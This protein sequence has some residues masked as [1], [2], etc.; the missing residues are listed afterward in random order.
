MASLSTL[1]HALT[2]SLG[3][4]S[5]AAAFF[6]CSDSTVGNKRAS[7]KRVS[8]EE[9]IRLLE[10][11]LRVFPETFARTSQALQ[12]LNGPRSPHRDDVE[13]I[14]AAMQR[15][16]ARDPAQMT[17]DT[18]DRASAEIAGRIAPVEVAR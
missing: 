17:G 9:D 2:T 4:I 8:V 5:A 11:K 3:G 6:D 13:T 15:I 12:A 1:Y 16:Y 10:D 18:R 7:D 14:H